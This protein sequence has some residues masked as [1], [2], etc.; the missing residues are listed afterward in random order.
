HLNVFET[1][2]PYDPLIIKTFLIILALSSRT[3][4]LFGKERYNPID[5]HPFPKELILAQN[6]YLMVFWKYAIYRLGYY[7][8][9][10]YS[11]RFIQHFLR[12]Q[13]I[14]AEILDVIRNRD[15]QGQLAGLF[16]TTLNI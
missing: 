7:E 3:S 10:I 1:F 16:E 2:L 6:Y 13:N 9:V 12:R 11:V 5:F 15:D 8:T 4:P 14:E